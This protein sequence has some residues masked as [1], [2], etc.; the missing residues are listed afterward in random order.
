M[1]RLKSLKSIHQIPIIAILE[2]FSD[3]IQIQYF[4]NQLNM[5]HA[6]SNPNGK[7]WLF[8]TK[9]IDCRI[10]ENEEQLITYEFNH[11]MN[12]NQFIVTFVYAK[13]KDHLRRPLWDSMLQQSATSLPWCTLGDF[14]VITDPQEK[15]GGVTYNMKKSLEFISII[16]ACGLQ[17]LG[18]CGQRYTWSNQRD[19]CPLLLEMTDQNHQHTKYFKFLNC[20][21]EQPSFLDTVSNCWNR[22]MEGNPMWCFHQKM[23]RLAATLSTWSRLQFG[24]IYAKV[25]EYEDKTRHAEEELIFSNSEENRTKLHA[26]NAEYIKYLKL[27]ESML[28]Q[29]TQLHWFKEGDVN[30]K[31]FHA[32]IRGRRR[33]LYIHKIQNK[34]DNWVQGEEN[35]AK[36]TCDHF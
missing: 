20:W 26:I 12:P 10:L 14:N 27:E 4:R 25:K 7:I 13:C 32:L 5:D 11:V 16:E 15:L 18:F 19:H 8:W 33:K 21:T 36:A 35:I 2:P 34:D 3:S 28:K 22:T 9:D 30:S 31:Y 1:E 6:I 17:D 24:D 29:K 23:K